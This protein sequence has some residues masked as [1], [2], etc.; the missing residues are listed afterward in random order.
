MMHSTFLSSV[1]TA[2]RL[3]QKWLQGS[4]NLMIALNQLCHLRPFYPE[5]QPLVLESLQEFCQTMVD[6]VSLGHFVVY[7]HIVNVIELCQPSQTDIPKDL[8]KQ[9]LQS[10]AEALDFNDKYQTN[11]DLKTLDKD[12]SSLAEHIAQR[13]EWE[14]WLL[15]IYRSAK[16]WRYLPAK[17]A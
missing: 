16:A 11:P 13:L 17:T 12:L 4:Q 5:N 9:L 3:V 2:D 8:L 1:K 15:E 6:Y 14:G 10:T 7:E